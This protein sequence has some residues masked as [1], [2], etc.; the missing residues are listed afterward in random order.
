MHFAKSDALETFNPG[1]ALR[2]LAV[3]PHRLLFCVGA[4]NV[5][6]AMLWWAL[7]LVNARWNVFSMAQPA[8]PA[9]WMHAIIMQYQVLPSFMFGFL[10][11]V[12]PR[13]MNFE[14]FARRHYVPVGVGLLGGQVLT[15]LG[16]TAGSGFLKAGGMLTT[17]G[18][19]VGTTL[20]VKLALRDGGKTWHAVSCVFALAFG[21]LGLLLYNLYLQQN[22]ARV[23]F[24]AIKI[25]GLAM[26]TPIFFT[27]C[28]R[29]I[30]FFAAAA[31]PGYQANR[32]MWVL[33]LFWP[34]TLLHVWL[35]L[36]HGYT[37]LWLADLPL[38]TLGA[39]LLTI[40]LPHER[41]MPP[42]LRVLFIGFAWLPIA[43]A[44]YATQSL[45]FA[46]TGEFILARAPAHALF[47]G[48]FGSLLVAM[49]T[50]VTQGHSGRPLVLGRIA[51]FAFIV[52]Q[53]VGM[54]RVAADLADDAF[55]WYAVA[56]VGWVVAFAPWV[57]RSTWIYLTPR[58]D[59][60]AG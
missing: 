13:W 21:L 2:L 11:T 16:L 24:V 9:G 38:A 59:G 39:W 54:T 40:W 56:G 45:W 4:A 29:M 22:D 35:E 60:K 32:P 14:P 42:L 46:L 30:P 12:F 34:L 28:H 44:L 33:A 55:A 23:M 43:F 25:G 50:R 49:V 53:A 8:A 58:A 48:F 27:V 18:F 41:K 1:L 10:L 3:A 26:L 5:L 15:L 20:L 52:I 37:W 6:L 47:I 36:R 31:L 19:G 7:W 17:F 51:A 57:V